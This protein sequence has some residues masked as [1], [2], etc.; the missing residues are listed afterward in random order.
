[1]FPTDS[2]TTPSNVL[3]TT[4]SNNANFETD[5]GGSNPPYDL[6]VVGQFAGSP[7]AFGTYD[8]GGDVFQWNEALVGAGRQ[9]CG[10][11]YAGPSSFLESDSTFSSQPS[12]YESVLGFRVAVVP[13]PDSIAIVFGRATQRGRESLIT[14][15]QLVG[16][17]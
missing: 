12:E 17:F 14:F 3:S 6:T 9:I 1:M 4:G 10:G 8:Q 15:S 13:E 7:S 5:A 2:D 16:L 11:A